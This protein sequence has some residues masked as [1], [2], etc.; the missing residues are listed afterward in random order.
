METIITLLAPVVALLVLLPTG[1]QRR[2]GDR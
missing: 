1:G 2:D